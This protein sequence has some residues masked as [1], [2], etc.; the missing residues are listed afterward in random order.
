MSEGVGVA[1]DEQDDG[2]AAQAF[3]ELRAE[4]TVIRRAIEGFPAPSRAWRRRTIRRRS[5]RSE[6][7][8][9]ASM[10]GLRESRTIQR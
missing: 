9:P 8:S 10:R 2:G 7:R 3:A 6:R 1:N 4:V 5:A